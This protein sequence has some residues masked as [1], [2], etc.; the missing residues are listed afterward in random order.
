MQDCASGPSALKMQLKGVPISSEGPPDAVGGEVQ[1]PGCRNR[2]ASDKELSE[3]QGAVLS[4]E[5]LAKLLACQVAVNV[6]VPKR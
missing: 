2:G 4:N 1:G 3:A 6:Q 5:S